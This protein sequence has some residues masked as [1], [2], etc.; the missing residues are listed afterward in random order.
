LDKAGGEVI[1][2]A[3][4]YVLVAFNVRQVARD[5]LADLAGELAQVIDANQSAH[6]D[7]IGEMFAHEFANRFE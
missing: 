1:R 4:N 6:S 2:D 3:V 5:A 7:F